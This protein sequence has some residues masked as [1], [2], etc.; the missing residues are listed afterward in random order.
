MSDKLTIAALQRTVAEQSAEV[1]RL[2]AL[3]VSCDERLDELG[4]GACY[5]P[6]RASVEAVPEAVGE[7]MTTMHKALARLR[8]ERKR[9][10]EAAVCATI[11][12]CSA[13][14]STRDSEAAMKVEDVDPAPIVARVLGGSNAGE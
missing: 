1:L 5:V 9:L 12:A 4:C 8:V 14:A 6:P 3:L 2:R 7:A 11:E 13:A 10:V